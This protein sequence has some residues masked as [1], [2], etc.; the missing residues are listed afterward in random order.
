MYLT[1][2]ESRHQAPL[3]KVKEPT[4]PPIPASVVPRPPIGRECESVLPSPQA[5]V[6]ALG[7]ALGQKEGQVT[8]SWER[9]V[10]KAGRMFRKKGEH[11]GDV[12]QVCP[13]DLGPEQRHSRCPPRGERATA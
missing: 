3:R 7:I 6:S 10:C 8:H 4:P 12:L 11:P 1:L 9:E 2:Q 5:R 13:Q